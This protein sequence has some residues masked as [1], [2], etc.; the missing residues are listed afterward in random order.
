MTYISHDGVTRRTALTL[1][2]ALALASKPGFG[3]PLQAAAPAA[4]L[5]ISQRRWNAARCTETLG[6]LLEAL[7]KHDA[8]PEPHTLVLLPRAD[9]GSDTPAEARLL[10]DL[11]SL[12]RAHKLWLATAA[13]VM[14]RAGTANIGVILSPDG[15][16][17]LRTTKATP[18]V[19]YGFTDT[20]ATLAAAM[21]F[22]IATTPFGK[23][24]LLVGE[25][26]QL[27]GLVRGTMLAGAELL[28]NPS[29]GAAPGTFDALAEAPSAMAYENWNMVAVAT[30]SQGGAS[31]SGL[32]DWRGQQVRAAPGEALLSVRL[33]VEPLRQA[34]AIVSPD[35]YDNFPVWL[36][37]ALFAE[38][39]AH[40]AKK[41]E[42][43]PALRTRQDW[44]AEGQ[45]RLA[46]QA[47]RQTHED[48]LEPYYLAYIAQPATMATLPAENRREALVQNIDT[49]LA[50]IG[51]LA[52]AP[53]AR[54]ALFP[55]FCFTGAGYRSIPDLL[56]V[57]CELPGPEVAR[58]QQWARDNSLYAAAQFME[59]DPK[60]P[61]RAFNTAV[62][63]D[64]RGEIILKHRKLQ[65]VDIL[66]ALPDT[67]PGSVFDAYV[68]ANGIESL[69][70]I[71]DTPLGK[72]G[73]TICFEL[74]MPEVMR[75]MTL[76]GA[77][78][79]LHLTAEGYGSERHMWHA[80]RRKRALENQAYLLC[81]NKGYDPAK[82]EPWV[83]YG[84]SQFID[85]RGRERDRI[86]HNGPGVLV[87]PVDMASLRAARADLRFNLSI[88]DEPAAYAHAYAQAK[89]V[90]N[91]LWSAD[92]LT[93][94]HIGTATLD[95]TR[96][97]Y[98]QRGVYM[99]PGKAFG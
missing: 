60:F 39:F 38:I 25:D 80:Q 11:A 63:I 28:L 20:S 88:W 99:R 57:A 33:D 98:Y 97:R 53:N 93:N 5:L 40:Q 14:T 13:P 4:R 68:A 85:F 54:L 42:A 59:A 69:Y 26:A 47:R 1:A 12:A 91:N 30:P 62:L 31:R 21:D 22:A 36:R 83:P 58:L 46:R 7:A 73:V 8:G 10:E 43:T 79:I 50:T 41:R 35:I 27:P 29:A 82:K 44:H 64:D 6:P 96:E 17:A 89:G 87:A 75:A 23:L 66:G 16:V 95:A 3:Q 65:C 76:A 72:I 45:R 94:P 52:K 70:A 18:D 74:N 48:K 56:T 51:R 37:D 2:A 24:G 19:F 49:A 92:P 55:E 15:I 61:N 86:S 77:E 81:S 78:I 90:P 71:A 9:P 84:E 67:T 32:F 34:R